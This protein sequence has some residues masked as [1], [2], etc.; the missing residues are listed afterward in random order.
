MS[1]ENILKQSSQV[2]KFQKSIDKVLL[3]K[4]IEENEGIWE[5]KLEN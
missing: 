4:N 5:S 2:P 3:M 1:I